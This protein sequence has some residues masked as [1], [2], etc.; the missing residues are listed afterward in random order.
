MQKTAINSIDSKTLKQIIDE[1]MVLANNADFTAGKAL[2]L[3]A[4]KHYPNEPLVFMNLGLCH[5]RL[6][7]LQAAYDAYQKTLAL[8]RDET[9]NTNLYDGLAEACFFLDKPEETK[10]YGRLALETKL[11]QIKKI[12]PLPFASKHPPA[13]NDKNPSENIISFSLFGDNPRYCETALL[14]IYW[15][16]KV[17]PNWTC[18]FYLDDSVP[19]HVKNRL[20][21]HGGQIVEVSTEIKQRMSGLFWRFLVIDDPSAKRFL[22]RDADSLVSFKERVAINAWLRSDKWFHT[23]RDFCSHTE[24]I[25]AGM[26]GGCHG[27]ID[28]IQEK[29]N[30]FHNLQA[31]GTQRFWDQHFLRYQIYPILSQSLLAHD[32]QDIQAGALPFPET[33]AKTDHERHENFHIGRNMATGRVLINTANTEHTHVSWQL[34]NTKS[35]DVI[36]GYTQPINGQEQVAIHLPD[37]HIKKL[38][39]KIF[40]IKTQFFTPNDR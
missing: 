27:A 11:S 16:K 5:L 6:K 32:S 39:Q 36:Y 25:L 20:Q 29:I 12:E 19:T 1:F 33:K 22:I 14:N 4:A 2:L 8:F 18:R 24:L 40:G 7:E 17:L 34:V 26:W 23:M 28:N 13:F 38:Q 30:T 10:K 9:P 3:Q 37:E 15:A 21:K 31:K 35:P